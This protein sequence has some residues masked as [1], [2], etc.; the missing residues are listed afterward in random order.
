MRQVRIYKQERRQHEKSE[1]HPYGGYYY[2]RVLE[3][4]GA[5]HQWGVA[6]EEFETGAGNYTT[7]I[8]ELSDGK[9]VTPEASMIEFIT[10]PIS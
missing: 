10:P 5:F 7:A 2:E 9:I 3:G 6:Y 4:E 8:V 1:Q